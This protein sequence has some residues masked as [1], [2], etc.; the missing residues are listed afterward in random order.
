MFSFPGVRG[1]AGVVL[2]V[3]LAQVAP[4]QE[5]KSKGPSEKTRRLLEEVAKVHRDAAAYSD[6]GVLEIEFASVPPG[7]FP[8]PKT[9]STKAQLA[10]ARPN[11]FA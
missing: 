9:A 6:N 1:L 3:V 10:F 11:K 8:K 7:R 4:G 5:L 2:F